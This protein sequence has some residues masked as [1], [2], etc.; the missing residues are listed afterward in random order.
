MAKLF[1]IDQCDLLLPGAGD[2]LHLSPKPEPS[3]LMRHQAHSGLAVTN[4]WHE[5]VTLSEED[6]R[7]VAGES[8]ASNEAA[9]VRT[10]LAF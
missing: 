6:R 8:F 4:R 10:G 2:W 3:L 1:A 7:W 9:L 5:V